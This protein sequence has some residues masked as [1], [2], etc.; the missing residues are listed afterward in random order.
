MSASIQ[1]FENCMSPNKEVR[2]NAEKDLEKM[3][4]MPVSNTINIFKDNF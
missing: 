2:T 3:K 1:F 4:S